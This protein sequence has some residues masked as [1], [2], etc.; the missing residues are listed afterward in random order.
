MIIFPFLAV[1]TLLPVPEKPQSI[2]EGS[3]QGISF[4]DIGFKY[5]G[6]TDNALSGLNLE[7]KQGELMALVGENG[8][9][10]STL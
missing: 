3:I 8:A 4:E 5:L 7:I 2:P 10:K 6:G 1:G 9:G